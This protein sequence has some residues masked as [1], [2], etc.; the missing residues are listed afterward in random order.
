MN[1]GL[2]NAFLGM[3]A[4]QHT[5]DTQSN[6]IANASTT[7]FK[8]ER[9]LY[10]SAE[11]GKKGDGNK[12]SLVGGVTANGGIDFSTGSIQQ[13]GRALDV[14]IDG[15]AFLQV[16]TPQGVRFTRAGNLTMN[17]DG[18]LVT[19]SG[20]LVVGERG[21]ITIPANKGEISIGEDGTI[22]AG[23]TPVDKLKMV[24]F[25]NPAAALQKAGGTLFMMTGT[26]APQANVNARVMQGALEGSNVN[27]ISEMVAMIN[28]NREFESLQKSVTLLMNDIGR[29]IS[30]EIGK[31]GG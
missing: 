27:S 29:K 18:Q 22:S 31:I 20:D 17:K 13:T 26:E 30:S 4:R 10:S 1:Y 21:P 24:H 9:L 25:N 19:N 23:K 14:A 3:R 6:N 16:Q 12:Q 5:L 28:N 7:G 2:Y 15:D 11:A 8:A